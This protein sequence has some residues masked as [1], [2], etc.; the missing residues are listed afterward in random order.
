MPDIPL[1]LDEVTPQWLTE[2]LGANEGRI[3][4]FSS[5]VVGEGAGFLG[6]IVRITPETEAGTIRPLILKMPTATA[7]RRIGQMLGVYEREVRFYR[8]LQPKVSIRTPTP[9]HC[10]MD[11]SDPARSLKDL[12]LLKRL[13]VWLV[14]LLLPVVSRLAGN[15]GHRY[16]LLM[17]D[18]GPFRMGD[19][20]SVCTQEDAMMAVAAL[21]KLHADFF[22]QDL[23]DYPWVIP[24]DLGARYLQIVMEKNYDE[25]CVRHQEIM[26]DQHRQILKWLLEHAE[27]FVRTIAQLPYTLLHGDYRPDNLC[28]DD[29]RGELIVMDWQTLLQGPVGV[30]VAYFIA[31][32][33]LDVTENEL[34]EHYVRTMAD[35]G[36]RMSPA[37]IRFE[38][39][40]GVLASLQRIM[41]LGS[42]D[43]EFGEG[44]GPELLEQATLRFFKAAENINLDTLLQRVIPP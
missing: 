16:V 13:P 33:E 4:R 18:L 6:D 23:S 24:F 27:E 2:A 32:S 11:E 29:E 25:F 7:N 34:L 36:I 35:S 5:E 37:R 3:I 30:D 21:A 41:L 44:R 20:L 15:A 10:D 26:S 9:F 38:Y 12:K 42:D 28:F 40:M 1:T 31:S 43:V 17:E 19:Q 39:E 14:K 22:E 8:E